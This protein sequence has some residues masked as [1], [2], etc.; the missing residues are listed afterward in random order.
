MFTPRGKRFRPRKFLKLATQLIDD[1]DYEELCRI[2]TAVGRA[3]Y[4]AFLYVRAKLGSLGY[5]LPDDHT[6]HRAVI[7]TLMERKD[8]T[9][10]SQ[11]DALFEKRRIADYYMDTPISK[12]EGNY[13]MKVS[14][15]V[16]YTSEKRLRGK[17]R[18]H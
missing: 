1:R 5:T 9:I 4:A 13:C 3:Y 8:T 16:I 2:R 12:G 18:S 10:G 15:R 6:V 14:E 11:L 7:D 17:R